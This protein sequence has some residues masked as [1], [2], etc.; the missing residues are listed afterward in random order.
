MDLLKQEEE[1]DTYHADRHAQDLFEADFLLVKDGGGN[2]YQHR[3]ERH[4]R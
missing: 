1:G 2:E 3:S 4:Q